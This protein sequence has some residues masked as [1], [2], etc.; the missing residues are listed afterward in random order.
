MVL[1]GVIPFR[2]SVPTLKLEV[3]PVLLCYCCIVAIAGPTVRVGI[4]VS[5][6]F[7]DY[8][9]FSVM[10]ITA[11]IME[12]GDFILLVIPPCY[13]LSCRTK[14]QHL[15]ELMLKLHYS[16]L[17]RKSF[18]LRTWFRKCCTFNLIYECCYAA[19]VVCNVF[20]L[21]GMHTKRGVAMAPWLI[22][23]L[24][25]KA[26]VLLVMYG[27][28]QYLKIAVKKFNA[29]F[30][31]DNNTTTVPLH[32]EALRKMHYG[33]HGLMELYEHLWNASK[34]MNGLFGVPLLSYLF[35]AF[36]HTTI[37][38]YVMIS[39]VIA[40][41][42]TVPMSV[43]VV[44]ALQFVWVTMDLIWLMKIIET[45]GKTRD[46]SRKTQK[47]LLRLNL[48]PMD[49][50]LKQSIEVFALQTMHQPLEFTACR[51]F[52]LDYTVLFSIAASVTNYL[53]ILIQFEM[54][55]EQ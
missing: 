28:L 18:P 38:Y 37:I 17:V 41:L 23:S 11:I 33:P 12:I 55:I 48:T 16:P 52:T 3:K 39:N 49:H 14:V 50:K 7:T 24:L 26:S 13:F 21:G 46:E 44:V 45:C 47:L 35:M 6:Y 15:F 54:A 8:S 31:A 34:A 10:L 1:L 42:S 19:I 43:I 9:Q 32:S 36:I 25:T 53:I 22:L 29:L 40:Q 5:V 30:A 2:L 20:A 51:M 27:S 4:Y